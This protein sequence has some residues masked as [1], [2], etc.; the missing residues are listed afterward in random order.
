MKNSGHDTLTSGCGVAGISGVNACGFVFLIF[1]ACQRGDFSHAVQRGAQAADCSGFAGEG[2]DRYGGQSAGNP[3]SSLERTNE[4]S[5]QA[6]VERQ[7]TENPG[8]TEA[9]AAREN[10]AQIGAHGRNGFE[11]EGFVGPHDFV[12]G[13]LHAHEK[14]GVFHAGQLHGFFKVLGAGKNFTAHEDVVGGTFVHEVAGLETGAVKK[15]AGGNPVW[16][17]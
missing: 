11:N 7:F 4:A 9:I 3:S 13:L 2:R 10:P 15:S 8:V 5:A 16:R 12:T 1:L 17:V 6:F 14:M